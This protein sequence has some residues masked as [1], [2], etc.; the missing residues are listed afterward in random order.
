[1]GATAAEPNA[2]IHFLN[3]LPMIQEAQSSGTAFQQ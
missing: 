1:M 2:H 3:P